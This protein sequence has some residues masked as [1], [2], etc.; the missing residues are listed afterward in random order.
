MRRKGAGIWRIGMGRC[1]C[2]GWRVPRWCPGPPIPDPGVGCLQQPPL[3]LVMQWQVGQLFKSE[4]SLGCA[5]LS[6]ASFWHQTH[7][8]P[9]LV[10]SLVVGVGRHPAEQCSA[11]A[12]SK[13]RGPVGDLIGTMDR[14]QRWHG[15][16]EAHFVLGSTAPCS[17]DCRVSSSS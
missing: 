12:S 15:M 1:E 9:H 2:V 5:G 11:V 16:R 17:A 14:W 8:L 13:S 10:L 7:P 3:W 6:Q 4:G